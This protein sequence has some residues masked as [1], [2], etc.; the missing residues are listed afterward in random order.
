MSRMK[1]PQLY[2][3]GRTKVSGERHSNDFYPTPTPT[4]ESL[5]RSGYLPLDDIYTVL[6]P[7]AG[8]G[9]ISKVLQKYIPNVI[10]TDLYDYG[11]PSVTSGVDFLKEEFKDIDAVITNP[12]YASNLL[13]PFIEKALKVSN[14]W[15]AM[16]LKLTFL[17]GKA[18][19]KFFKKNRQLRYVLVFSNRQDLK[20]N[21]IMDG[22]S[23]AIAYAWYI[24][25]KE[26]NGQPTI[27]WLENSD[28]MRGRKEY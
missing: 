24:W 25:D 9:H 1:N 10:A 28:K 26:Y 2:T 19:Y 27:D 3:G 16:L 8:K 23:S 6:E 15:V 5:M 22:K 11:E 17:E 7:A 4:T 21:G 14:R 18:R 20:M 13:M 12:P